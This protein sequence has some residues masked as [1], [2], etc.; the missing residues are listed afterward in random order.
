MTVLLNEDVADFIAMFD[1]RNRDKEWG[2]SVDVI[3]RSIA[4]LTGEK[5]EE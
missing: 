1:Y 5:P 4:F 2:K 3:E